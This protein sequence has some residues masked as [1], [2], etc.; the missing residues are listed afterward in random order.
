MAFDLEYVMTAC[1][2]RVKDELMLA[3]I[4]REESI[5]EDAARY[6]EAV[7][8]DRYG[9]ALYNI[10]NSYG[11]R[12]QFIDDSTGNVV[13]IISILHNIASTPKLFRK[14]PSDYNRVEVPQFIENTYLNVLHYGLDIY[15]AADADVYFGGPGYV[16]V[17][18][19]PTVTKIWEVMYEQT[20]IVVNGEQVI[21]PA[22]SLVIYRYDNT[23]DW[24]LDYYVQLSD[25][26]FCRGS[27]VRN[28]LVLSVIGQLERV[29]DVDKL[30]QQVLKSVI[31][32]KG[33]NSF[34][35]NYG[36]G[37]VDS[38]GQ[39][40]TSSWSLRTQ[41]VEQLE[42][43]KKYQNAMI[44][45]SPE[46]YSA[47]ELLDDLIGIKAFPQQDPRNLELVVTILNRALERA[48]SK[49]LRIK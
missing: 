15:Y 30:S 31:T 32:K 2:H 39:K 13:A 4:Q 23:Y 46:L 6:G 42:T 37:L 24:F 29:Y 11:E 10:T 12:G 1:D 36:T 25:C 47:R 49:V 8:G 48:D 19:T 5:Y 9:D 34:F 21:V 45:T 38:I 3:S 16:A 35:P 28:D 22:N 14:L 18:Q 7:Y 41:I 44:N 43:I 17:E 33:K 26:P 27:G 40:I 20:S